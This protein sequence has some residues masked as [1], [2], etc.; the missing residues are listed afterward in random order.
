M[1][2]FKAG[3]VVSLWV[4]SVSGWSQTKNWPA[5]RGA[6]HNGIAQASNLPAEF[7]K[8]KNMLWRTALPGAA[9]STP[10]VWGDRIYLSSADGEEGLLMM[11]FD[12]AGKEIW[13]KTVKGK[14]F[15]IRRG[16]SNAAAPSPVTD[17]KHIWFLF[18]T[19]DF[20]CVN[21][22]GMVIWH[23][24]L[25]ETYAKFNM[26]HGYASSPLLYNKVMYVQM[27]HTDGQWVVALDPQTGKELWKH[28][29]DS[30]AKVE[31]LHSY[32]SP[33]P[34]EGDTKPVLVIHG[35]DYVTGHDF[36]NGKEIW[37]CGGL[38]NPERYNDYF[39]LVATP[40]AGE[41]LLV[42]P[43][44]K[45]GPVWGLR[46]KGASG[47]LDNKDAFHAWKMKDNTPDVPSAIIADGLVYLCRENGI[48][49]CLDAKTGKL[50]YKERLHAGNHRGSPVLADN[51]IYVPAGDGTV[52]VVKV[53]EAFEVL[54]KNALEERI[55]ASPVIFQNTLLI[56]TYK[57]LYAFGS[58]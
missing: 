19:G 33:I 29:R 11:A 23:K 35:S 17:G 51:K 34:F 40:V 20:L 28:V 53:G 18:G 32:A 26:Y 14:N 6:Q 13:R 36:T 57:A 9:P 31:S 47:R 45:N 7:S 50:H 4:L 42:V 21:T 12:L 10:A 27:L 24:N 44:A 56:R 2:I 54:A 37:R 15:S 16:E 30:D 3:M 49:M 43:S 52:S 58:K 8:D 38:Q 39:R 1:R 55:A 25:V 5:W 22:D 41:G 46:P 48:F